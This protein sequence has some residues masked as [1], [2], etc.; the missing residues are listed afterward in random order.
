[1]SL[2]A[3]WAT[4]SL[5]KR[6]MGQYDLSGVKAISWVISNEDEGVKS[7]KSAMK[8]PVQNFGLWFT[9]SG[10]LGASPDGLIGNNGILEIKCPF[11]QRNITVE[12]AVTTC[13]D[14]FLLNLTRILAP[15]AGT[16]SHNSERVLLFCNVRLMLYA[17]HVHLQSV[18]FL[19]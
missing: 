13:K 14:C 16:T 6:V 2:T 4:P 1:M 5:I 15:G 17:S 7:F 10:I 9:T 11:A 19:F 3:K 18:D 8:K 12:E